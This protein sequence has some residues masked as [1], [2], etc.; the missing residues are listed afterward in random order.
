VLLFLTIIPG[1]SL[2]NQMLI[3]ILFVSQSFFA[4]ITFD[5]DFESG[6][7]L[8]VEEIDSVSF[9]V[10]STAD[11]GV[12][13]GSTRW[14]YFR[15]SGVKDK[16]IR[17][18]FT[19]TDVTKAM[20]SYDNNTFVRFTDEEAPSSG[21]FFKRFE[22]DT[23]YISYYTPY[24]Y[25]YLQSR[26]NTWESNQFVKIDTLGFSPQGLPIQEVLITDLSI[27]D[28]EKQ[29]I[30]IHA[31]T[32]TSETPS[33]WHFD[34]IIRELLSGDEAVNHYLK[35]L[36]FHMIPFTNPDGVFYGRSRTNFD[37]I[38]LETNWDKSEALTSGEVKLLRARMKELNDEKP[39]SVFLN[40]HS[41]SVS[42]CTFWIH[43]PGSTSESF[44]T[45]EHQFSNLNISDNLYFVHGDL[46]ES[47]LKQHY[48]EGWLWDN[49]GD[50][51][52][53][54]TY[55]TPYDSYF[56]SSSEPYIEVTNE[57]LF[58]IG[59]RTVYSIAE[60]LKISHPHHYLIDNI[61]AEVVGEHNNY[62]VGNE[63]FG[64]NFTVLPKDVVDSYVQFN[65]ETLPSGKYDIAAWWPTSDEYSF[66][67]V[68]EISAG[69]NYYEYSKAQNVEGNG[70]Q[71]NYLTTVE[72]NEEGIISIKLN[73]NS[74][75]LVVADA[76]RLI[77]VEPVTNINEV[78]IPKEFNLSQNYPNPFNPTTTIRYS[79]PNVVSNFGSVSKVSLRVYDVVGR[80]I[81]TLVNGQQ[82]VGDYEAQFNGANLASGTYFYRLQVGDFVETKKMILLK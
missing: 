27:P 14:I 53:A 72:L 33:S 23:V 65:S 34:G 58:E 16:D 49:Y 78:I 12:D 50:K 36:V 77:Y 29:S 9:Y 5:A 42:Y 44:Y 38:N 63:Y 59:R 13:G 57:N 19:N 18:L 15:M 76:F 20:Y 21:I 46:R 6:N 39:F 10:T 64:E 81:T 62:V 60:Y 35:K 51:V 22:E 52:M 56:S 67:T 47:D 73:G 74:T 8:S 7:L 40:L 43:K 80:E 75:G 17:V 79:I 32:H 31:R 3:L 54:L 24:S 26:I 61:S 66:A 55:E 70:G 37:G 30:W 71:W 69:S 82:T 68:Y 2:K 28:S 4:Q 1:G 45:R 48:P 11:I 41:Q 25:N